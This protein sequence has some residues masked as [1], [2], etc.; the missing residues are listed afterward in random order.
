M[1]LAQHLAI[2]R[3]AVGFGDGGRTRQQQP[4][5]VGIAP[6][7]PVRRRDVRGAEIEVQRITGGDVGIGHAEQVEFLRRH[8]APGNR[9]IEQLD[10]QVDADLAQVALHGLHQLLPGRAGEAVDDRRQA[11][12]IFR[13]E[14]VGS[15]HPAGGIEDPVRLIHIG[16]D[17]DGVVALVPV[18]GGLVDVGIGRLGLAEIQVAR[19][20]LLVDRHDDGPA[21]GRIVHAGLVDLEADER[22]P[23]GGRILDHAQVAVGADLGEARIGNVLGRLGLAGQ[24]GGKAGILLR[25]D[26]PDDLLDMRRTAVL[27]DRRPPAVGIVAAHAHVVARAPVDPAIGA[28]AVEAAHAIVGAERLD[29]GLVDD[30]REALGQL[31]EQLGERR[32]QTIFDGRVVNGD[33]VLDR[34]GAP[35]HRRTRRRIDPAL[36]RIDDVGGGH[37]L[38]VAELHVAPQL[39][40][41][42]L[43][44][45]RDA[46][47]FG[48]ARLDGDHVVVERDQRIRQHEQHL[49]GRA[50]RRAVRIV[51]V[52][53]DLAND[54]QRVLLRDRRGG[55]AQRAGQG[56][57]PQGHASDGHP[58][59][60]L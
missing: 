12:A 27:V 8:L 43:A 28:R 49:G 46:P 44:V 51:A 54:G 30:H 1:H 10:A 60:L 48:E 16:P 45:G 4:V 52:A 15:A 23:E 32:F 29:I 18:G 39:E 34:A 24:H 55:D 17:Q 58:S 13:A 20:R 3:G 6:V 42:D 31:V 11:L 9:R 19:D 41:I 22:R 36:D 7:H 47:A 35:A 50:G 40:G 21:H 25:H 38:A 26:A 2:G 37:L 5:G 57:C 53:V 14:A 33:D 59:F 56:R